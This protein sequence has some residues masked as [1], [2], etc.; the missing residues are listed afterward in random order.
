MLAIDDVIVQAKGFWEHW[1]KRSK[2]TLTVTIMHM[3][4]YICGFEH[5]F[6]CVHCCPAASF[7]WIHLASLGNLSLAE[8]FWQKAM[9]I[10]QPLVSGILLFGRWTLLAGKRYESAFP[11]LYKWRL[12]LSWPPDMHRL[13]MPVQM[14]NGNSFSASDFG[15]GACNFRQSIAAGAC[16]FS[17]GIAFGGGRFPGCPSGCGNRGFFVSWRPSAS[18]SLF[19]LF[20]LT[21][22]AAVSFC[23]SAIS[24]LPFATAAS[25]SESSVGCFLLVSSRCPSTEACCRTMSNF[26]TATK[27]II[28][29]TRSRSSWTKTSPVETPHCRSAFWQ[30]RVA[31]LP[32]LSFLSKMTHQDMH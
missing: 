7:C 3:I 16:G 26:S 27:S 4:A 23:S 10:G 18:S 19:L 12:I 14:Q 22:L 1:C 6:E 31:G 24:E 32:D 9:L 17:R 5:E 28:T 2:S 30:V 29:S 25:F 21:G 8:Y 13:S 15:K 20:S 11:T